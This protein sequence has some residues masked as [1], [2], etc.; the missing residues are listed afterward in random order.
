MKHG[1][2]DLRNLHYEKENFL[3]LIPVLFTLSV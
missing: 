1:G 2:D 3:S